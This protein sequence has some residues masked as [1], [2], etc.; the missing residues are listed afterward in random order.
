MH[1]R[2]ITLK[3]LL[4]NGERQIGLKFYPNELIHK[5]VKTLPN[6]KWS[7]EFNMVYLPNTKDNINL[8]FKTFRGLVWVNGQHF[9]G[10]SLKSDREPFQITPPAKNKPEGYRYCPDE[11]VRKLQINRYAENTA[12][13]YMSCFEAFMNYHK[14]EKLLDID[15]NDIR[16]YLQKLVYDG[17]SDSYLNQAVNAIKFYYE[18]VL[19]MPNRFYAIDRPRKKSA[20]PKVL[21]KIEIKLLIEHASNIKHKCI[22]GLLYSA[23]LRRRELL[24]LKL[25]DID[26]KRMIVKVCEGK[27]GKQRQTLLSPSVLQ[28]LRAYYKQWRP[29]RYLFEG[30]PGAQYSPTSVQ[31][32]VKRAAQKAGLKKRVTPHMLRHSF[33]THLLEDGVDLRYIQVLL[34]HSSTKTT[35]IYT[36]VAT[37]YMINITSPIDTLP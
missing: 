11:Y 3:H 16:N 33:A 4:I 14:E 7:K 28:D 22:I 6:P 1:S 8:I 9:F 25:T 17:K 15:E 37:N 13:I 26:S 12:K 10:T 5:L 36:Q 31:K 23:G 35:E 18:V 2:V 20:L 27:G 32:V 30:R 19:E 24:H 21:S 29:H 34:G